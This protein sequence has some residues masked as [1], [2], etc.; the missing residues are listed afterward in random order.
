MLLALG[1]DS[2]ILGVILYCFYAAADSL[3]YINEARLMMFLAL[4][5]FLLSPWFI[6][7]GTLGL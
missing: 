1:I 6:V 7:G 3:G 4:A 5:M 2:I